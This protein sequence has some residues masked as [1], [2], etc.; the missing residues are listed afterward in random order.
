MNLLTVKPF[1]LNLLLKQLVLLSFCMVMFPAFSAG[2]VK[3]GEMTTLMWCNASGDVV[4]KET[5]MSSVKAS[6]LFNLPKRKSNEV[7]LR[8]PK[9]NNS[10]KFDYLWSSNPENYLK[11]H[12]CPTKIKKVL[13]TTTKTKALVTSKKNFIESIRMNEV[14]PQC[15]AKLMTRRGEPSDLLRV[16]EELEVNTTYVIRVPSMGRDYLMPRRFKSGS[17]RLFIPLIPSITTKTKLDVLSLGTKACRLGQ[18][19]Y[20]P[21]KAAPNAF[22]KLIAAQADIITHFIEL[23]GSSIEEMR[24]DP[25]KVSSNAT[26]YATMYDFLTDVTNP[27]SVSG[28]FSEDIEKN[29]RATDLLDSI[30]AKTKIIKIIQKRA[31]KFQNLP[32]PKTEVKAQLS[33]PWSVANLI[34]NFKQTNTSSSP[35]FLM[36]SPVF[37]AGANTWNNRMQTKGGLCVSVNSA[38]QLSTLFSY[39]KNSAS[40][41]TGG[42]IGRRATDDVGLLASVFAD[43]NLPLRAVDTALKPVT[44]TLDIASSLLPNKLY[45]LRFDVR[46]KSFKEDHDV[47]EIYKDIMVDAKSN[48]YKL[49]QAFMSAVPISTLAN[50]CGRY[51]NCYLDKLKMQPKFGPCVYTN[52]KLPYSFITANVQNKVVAANNKGQFVVNNAGKGSLTISTKSSK[53]SGRYAE[54]AKRIIVNPID[55]GISPMVTEL[56]ENKPQQFNITVRNAYDTSI[57]WEISSKFS[58]TVSGESEVIN[59]TPPENYPGKCRVRYTLKVTSLSKRGIRGYK[60]APERSTTHTFLVRK[61]DPSDEACN[62]IFIEPV[63]ACID[64]GKS[65]Q[66]YVEGVGDAISKNP[67]VKWSASVG[68]INSDGLYKSPDNYRSPSVTIR[69]ETTGKP[70]EMYET[71]IALGCS[72]MYKFSSSF[73][74]LKGDTVGISSN[75]DTGDITLALGGTFDFVSGEIINTSSF[76]NATTKENMKG[77]TSEEISAQVSIGFDNLIASMS[78][79]KTVV[80]PLSI[81]LNSR[82]NAV[83][84]FSFKAKDGTSYYADGKPSLK[85]SADNKKLFMGEISG[86]LSDAKKERSGGFSFKFR[87]A[88]GAGALCPGLKR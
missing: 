75:L 25:S 48:T 6:K 35:V 81:K 82:F 57:K 1:L 14:F 61:E 5:K 76:F 70:L 60:R 23:N 83:D 51:D 66:F 13:K 43:F 24:S 19:E 56:I 31:N 28:M 40:F 74:S 53:F 78:S 16:S 73:G 26:I 45:N 22:K 65:H 33:T 69:A 7:L 68:S 62:E 42:S 85:V 86:T 30:V 67:N 27:N 77:K 80:P 52:V 71:E 15:K 37:L 36:S 10:K 88:K 59:F 50:F 4:R 21:L 72:C 58:G 18:V 46:N 49:S 8:C 2:P 54:S 17:W 64:K 47:T 38:E 63:P 41:T 34:S 87:A 20:R 9:T 29:K 12:C 39:Q 3:S 44:I 84:V 79:P 55:I 32:F 11:T